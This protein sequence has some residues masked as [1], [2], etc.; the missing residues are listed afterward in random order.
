MRGGL[1]KI[2]IGKYVH[3][4]KDNHGRHNPEP[5]AEKETP[6][7]VGCLVRRHIVQSIAVHSCKSLEEGRR[8]GRARQRFP[9][10]LREFQNG[11][12][13]ALQ[14]F[15]SIGQIHPDAATLQPWW[16]APMQPATTM[17]CCR[18]RNLVTGFSNC[19]NATP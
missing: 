16:C 9:F 10:V 3:C 2:G 17:S 13:R 1:G 11:N 15:F 8:T 4:H 14:P 12:E 6:P 19:T 7:V 5:L 18:K